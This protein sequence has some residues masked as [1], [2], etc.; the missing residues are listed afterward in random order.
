MQKRRI[1]RA[2]HCDSRHQH[3]LDDIRHYRL[4]RNDAIM[5]QWK[6]H[7]GQ[8]LDLEG[9]VCCPVFATTPT[10]GLNDLVIANGG[11]QYFGMGV[12]MLRH[13][14]GSLRAIPHRH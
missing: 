5:Q 9:S 6:R 1:G 14:D 13:F 11:A 4:P 3:A 10:D 2:I 8:N 7:I 12:L